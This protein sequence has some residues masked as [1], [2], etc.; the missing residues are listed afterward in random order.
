MALVVVLLGALLDHVFALGPPPCGKN[1][2]EVFP[3]MRGNW[4]HG[5]IGKATGSYCATR[6]QDQRDCPEAKGTNATCSMTQQHSYKPK[7]WAQHYCEYHCAKDIDC[8]SVGNIKGSCQLNIVNK[9]CTYS[10]DIFTGRNVVSV[11]YSPDGKHLASGSEDAT[12]K[13][14]E[15]AMGTLLHTL[16][17]HS[18]VVVSV[19]YSPD[20]K[21]LASGS[22]DYT[23]KI[24]EVATGTLLHTLAG[25]SD[26]VNSVAYSPDGKQLASGSDDGTII[27]ID[28]ATGL[29]VLS[30]DIVV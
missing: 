25:H 7:K 2:F 5:A 13:I 19:A 4:P 22:M 15:V 18:D 16:A 8:P 3:A 17:G 30:H 21:H 14:W 11:A 12:T 20:G 29:T 24:W 23:T 10:G 26:V 9:I 27:F 1:E 28:V 6:C